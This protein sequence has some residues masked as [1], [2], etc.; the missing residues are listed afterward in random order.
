MA[1]ARMR[2]RR[3]NSY[4]LGCS[5]L[6]LWRL[7]TMEHRLVLPELHDADCGSGPIY[8]LEGGEADQVCEALGT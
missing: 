1:P 5:V 2:L 7:L 3:C 8:L 4:V 6:W